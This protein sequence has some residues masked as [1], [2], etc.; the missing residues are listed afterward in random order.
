MIASMNIDC[1]SF[2]KRT[3]KFQAVRVDNRETK[4]NEILKRYGEVFGLE[5]RLFKTAVVTLKFEEEVAPKFYKAK[6]VAYALKPQLGILEAIDHSDWESSTVVLPKPGR[7]VRICV[8]FK[9]I[10]NPRLDIN[11][12]PLQKPEELFH[13]LNGGQRFSNIDLKEAHLQLR[14]DNESKKYMIINTQKGLFQYQRLP[15]GIIHL[16]RLEMMLKRLHD[17]GFRVKKDKYEILK[18]SL[19]YLGHIVD[20]EDIRKSPNK[21][22]AIQKMTHPKKL[23]ELQSFLGIIT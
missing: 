2:C 7:A 8:D 10:L 17:Y 5:L 18:E 20:A 15:F 4:L 13:A 21:M 16:E 1:G 14:L 11:Q 12:Y 9:G 3:S 22:E 23:K 19:E 6:P